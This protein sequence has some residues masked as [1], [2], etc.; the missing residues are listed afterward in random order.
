MCQL[1]IQTQILIKGGRDVRMQSEV[2]YFRDQA[3]G[4]PLQSHPTYLFN[5]GVSNSHQCII[6]IAKARIVTLE[7]DTSGN[8]ID[9]LT[10]S[11]IK[12]L[13]GSRQSLAY[14]LYEA[15]ERL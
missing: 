5:V 10:G 7:F 11:E 8:L 14:S 15:V 4:Y 9:L 1:S 2:Y 3:F 6:G 13:M 12:E